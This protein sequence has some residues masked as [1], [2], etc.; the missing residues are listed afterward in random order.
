[1]GNRARVEGVVSKPFEAILSNISKTMKRYICPKVQ[2]KY[3][4]HSG[5]FLDRNQ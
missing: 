2:S 4:L 5:N 3:C 1:M